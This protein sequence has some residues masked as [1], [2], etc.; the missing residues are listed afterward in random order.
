ML[1]RGESGW[2]VARLRVR[3]EQSIAN[4]LE[5]KRARG[6]GVASQSNEAI[7]FTDKYYFLIRRLHSLSGI[8]P[9]GAFLC[10][11][12]LANA[13]I[14]AAKDGSEYQNAV[15]RIHLL[16]PLLVPVEIAFI[17]APLAF[18]AIVGIAIWLTAK[19]NA[20]HYKKFSN[21]RYTLQRSTGILAA[22]FIVYHLWQMHWMGKPLG[23][24]IFD[25]HDAANSA[26]AAIQ[27][28]VWIQIVYGVGVTA[29]VFHFANGIWTSLITWGITIRPRTQQVSGYICATFGVVLWLVGLGALRGFGTFQ[30]RESSQHAV[31]AEAPETED[32]H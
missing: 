31:T 9:V 12:L 2:V 32:G 25:D 7:A 5:S 21:F 26:A 13:S 29:C 10:V 4:K 16:G 3:F 19:S 27:S 11:H 8:V 14:L 20:Q 1:G 15:D 18:H 30:V 24:G 23:G 22:A 6:R 28:A 17:F